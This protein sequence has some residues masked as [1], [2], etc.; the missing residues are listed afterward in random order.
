LKN[1]DLEGKFVTIN[2]AEAEI[3]SDNII[4]IYFFYNHRFTACV[5]GL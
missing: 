5:D 4:D 3:D 2:G 1:P